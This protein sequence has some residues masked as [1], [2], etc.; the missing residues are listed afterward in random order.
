MIK[1]I[2]ARCGNNLLLDVRW[3]SANR[4]ITWDGESVIGTCKKCGTACKMFDHG[5]VACQKGGWLRWFHKFCDSPAT[6]VRAKSILW[7]AT[8]V[9][10]FR[11]YCEHHHREKTKGLE[12]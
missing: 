8:G 2:C 6:Q 12:E 5:P 3:G 4:F 9:V 11:F 1:H 10:D 7:S